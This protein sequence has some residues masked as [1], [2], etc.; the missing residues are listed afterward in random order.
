[1]KI[2]SSLAAL[3]AVG[4]N[5]ASAQDC[6]T[7]QHTVEAPGMPI[8]LDYVADIDNG[9]FRG[10]VTYEG[11]GWV[12]FAV[13]PAGFM[14]GSQA[15]IGNDEGVNRYM[16]DGYTADQVMLMDFGAPR[17]IEE[18]LTQTDTQS[19]LEFAVPITGTEEQFN[20]KTD[21]DT[22][23]FLVAAGSSNTLSY[24]AVRSPLE[25]VV[26]PCTGGGSIPTAV[27]PTSEFPDNMEMMTADMLANLQLGDMVFHEGFVLDQFCID[28]GVFLDQPTLNS[29]EHPDKH[30]VHCLIDA[31]PCIATPFEVLMDPAQGETTWSRAFV[32]DQESKDAVVALAKT[33]GGP[34]CTECDGEGHLR[35]GFRVRIGGRVT[36]LADAATGVPATVSVEMLEAVFPYTGQA[37][38]YEGFIVDQFCLDAGTFLDNGLPA[39]TMPDRHTVHCLID[40]AVCVESPFEVLLEPA[41]G[42]DEYQRGYTLDDAS[43]EETIALIKSVG[44]CDKCDGTGTIVEGFRASFDATVVDHSR[45]LETGSGPLISLDGIE[46]VYPVGQPLPAVDLSAL[47]VGDSVWHEGFVLD[48]F[49]IDQGVFLDQPTLNSLEHPDKH[50]VHCLI[51]APPCIATPFELL[52]DPAEGETTWSRAFVLDDKSKDAVVELAKTL[53]GPS[54]TECN[55]EG[56]LRAGFRVRVGGTVTALADAA[57]GVPATISI[58]NLQAVFPYTGQAIEVEGYISDQ[59]CLDAGTFLDNG[60]HSLEL[61]DR[62]TVHCL[63]DPAVCVESPFEVLLPP[64]NGLKEYQRGYLLDDASKEQAIA[65]AKEVGV[66]DKCDGTGTIVEGFQ[67]RL[68]ATVLNHERDLETGAGALI[69][70]SNIDAIY[71]TSAPLPPVVLSALEVGSEVLYEGYVLDQFC[72]QQGV[73]LDQPDLVALEHPD[74]HTVHC[75]IDAPPCIATPFEIL[76][77]PA[78]GETEWGRAF[79]LDEAS[80]DAVVALAKTIGGPSCTECNGEGHLRAGF[81]VRVEGSVTA[82]ADDATGVPATLSVSRVQAV[83]PYTGQAIEVEAYISDQFCLE[84]GTFLDNGLPSLEMPDKHTVHCLI[85]PA[86]CVESPFEVLLP[87]EGR[88][89]MY[90]RGYTLDD[91]SKEQAVAL[92]KQVGVCDK[93][94]GTGSIV[95]GFRATL[96]AIVVD[97]QRN[98]TSGSGPLI[99]VSSLEAVFPPAEFAAGQEISIEGYVTDQ[100]CI[101]RGSFLDTGLVTLENAD[102]HT[103]HCLLDPPPCLDSPFEILIDPDHSSGET[104]WSRGFTLDEAS[105]EL[106]IALGRAVGNCDTCT[107]GESGQLAGFRVRLTAT[108]VDPGRNFTSGS[109]P[110]ISVSDAVSV[111]Q[112][113]VG[114]SVQIEGYVVDTFCIEQGVFLDTGLPVLPNGDKHTVHCLIDAPPCIASPYELLIDPAK[115]GGNYTRGFTLDEESKDK[116]VALAK[117][118]GDSS[119]T[120]CEGTGPLKEGFRVLVTATVVDNTRDGASG[121]G[122]LIS[123]TDAVWVEPPERVYQVGDVVTVEGYVTDQFCIDRGNFLDT[124]LVTLENAHRHTLHCLLDPPPCLE[125]PFEILMDP[126]YANGETM[127]RRGF[128][129]D[130]ASKEQVIALGREVGNCDTCTGGEN[131]QL[132]GFRVSLTAAVVEVA[133]PESGAGPVIS[134]SEVESVGQFSVGQTTHVEGYVIDTFCIEQGVFLDTK[135]PTLANGDKHTV[136]CL[137]DAPPCIA[138]PYE[139]VYDPIKEGGNW[140]RAFTLDQASKDQVVALA[141]E[142]GECT[143]CDGTGS[144]VEGFRV[145][146][147]AEVVDNMWNTTT[148]SGP[149]ISIV[150]AEAILPDTSGGGCEMPPVSQTFDAVPITFTYEMGIDEESGR[151]TFSATVE[152]A[153]EGWVAFG[154]SPD[155]R[156]GG[157]LAVIGLPDED[158]SESN[159]GKY[160]LGGYAQT[161]VV[162]TEQQTLL[163]SNIVQND[164]HTVLTFTKFLEEPDELAIDPSGENNFLVAAGSSNALAYHGTNRHPFKEVLPCP[165]GVPSTGDEDMEEEEPEPAGPTTTESDGMVNCSEYQVTYAYPG[166]DL[167][168]EYVMLFDEE[169]GEGNY[170]AQVTFA[171]QGWVGFGVSPNGAMVGSEAIIG[172]PDQDVGPGNPGVYNLNAQS[173]AGVVLADD[174]AQSQILEANIV[175]NDTHTVLT[176]VRTLDGAVPIVP[177]Q[178]NWFLTASG[179]SNELG[180]HSGRG[181]VEVVVSACT[182]EGGGASGIIENEARDNME[183]HYQAHGWLACIAWGVLVPIAIGNSLCRHLIP[184]QGLWF[185]VHR[186]FNSLAIVMTIVLFAI[187]VN[188]VEK[189]SFGDPQHFKPIEGGDALSK[190]KTIGL[191]VFILALIQ[192]IGGVMRPHLPAK[193]DDGTLAE[194]VSPIRKMWEF[195]HK[196]SGVAILAM[197]WY[198]CH[199]GLKTYATN[200]QA[201]D[202]T[203]VFWGVTGAISA[204]AV[205]GG[206]TRFAMPPE[207]HSPV[208]TNDPMAEQADGTPAQQSGKSWVSS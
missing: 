5:S 57:T 186:A 178:A 189:T 201:E 12:G 151:G 66:C 167:T 119:C 83:F 86:V 93:C 63:I 104:M 27:A 115:E 38:E 77:D 157:S 120:E 64:E 59:F 18:S 62:H 170:S 20:I 195:A 193:N 42:S 3:A 72:I 71:P 40:P 204:I 48:Q 43:K 166:T 75:L 176:F 142:V 96:D 35:T 118:V 28:Q 49:C 45:N 34:S 82:L 22:N 127:F 111:G 102:M 137:I 153:G 150:N 80:K 69:S 194:E 138:S 76:S 171:G 121:A 99:S 169:T 152:Y 173:P 134:V 50:T 94:D 41:Y 203:D 54:C 52:M 26:E 162:L 11:Q 208:A 24:H 202:Y 7:Y 206:L 2:I 95:E 147:I 92:A 55:G 97:H 17:G 107:G 184:V 117:E 114:Q 60:L 128:V 140:T 13:S 180:F 196:G 199:S 160:D 90:Q 179:L 87:P 124:G 106:V 19:I 25:V 205:I 112:Y 101:Q 98:L 177:D 67:A 139:I 125:S 146:L 4:L 185:E 141:K 84:A 78:E 113:S 109:G 53:G 116:I 21:G 85:D 89:T 197:A 79:V 133:D 103:F 47:S 158:I 143:D 155:G 131:G 1:M 16:L 31:P 135:L 122:P 65:L 174:S 187:V 14:A 132:A 108:I 105:K 110:L 23:F 123:V 129:L 15:V 130:D 190:H 46:P 191:V 149:L 73:F 58:S 36:A 156:M 145:L 9:V 154:I 39:L 10:R 188:A 181:N 32:L 165:G 168:L 81:R 44:V 56:H 144:L 159:P 172:F 161:Q 207:E 192:G 126:D 68:D 37:I 163:S 136:H 51:D 74:K 164:T 100:F 8:T 33:L 29:L 175:Q 148:G 70:V 88:S 200:F 61:P 198:Q 183:S 182:A 6:S 30:T 91:A